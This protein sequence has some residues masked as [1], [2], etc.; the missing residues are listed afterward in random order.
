[1][2]IIVAVENSW[3]IGNNG[4]LLDYFPEDLRYFR[5]KT[6]GKVLIMGRKTYLSIPNAPLK[7]RI[8]IILSSRRDFKRD[9]VLVFNSVR[10]TINFTAQFN[11]KDIFIIGGQSIYL[12]F[13]SMC[14][15]I[16]L[17]KINHDYDSDVFFLNLDSPS[18][19]KK[20]DVKLIN[21]IKSVNKGIQL[22]FFEYSQLETG[23]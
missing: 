17:T 12:Q 14:H 15:K 9:G 7:D 16:Y 18:N 8:N 6:L 19:S 1:M 22:D 23:A 10:D 13:I 3:G 2:N 5:E 21:S 11:S 20:F 4:K